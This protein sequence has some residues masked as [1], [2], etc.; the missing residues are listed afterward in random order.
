MESFTRGIALVLSSSKCEGRESLSRF[1]GIDGGFGYPHNT[2]GGYIHE[3]TLESLIERLCFLSESVVL[4]QEICDW[5]IW[6][7]CKRGF[8]GYLGRGLHWAEIYESVFLSDWGNLGGYCL[9]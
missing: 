5:N 4:A 9:G 1:I 7:R 8:L 3:R 2:D 6:G